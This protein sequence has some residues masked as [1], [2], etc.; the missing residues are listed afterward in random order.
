MLARRTSGSSRATR[1]SGRG[2]SGDALEAEQ[3]ERKALAEALHDEALQNLL[4]VRHVLEEIGE[5]NSDAEIARVDE[6]VAETVA[7]LRDV[8]LMSDILHYQTFETNQALGSKRF[9]NIWRQA[10]NS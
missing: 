6:T 3:R 7:Q 9:M 8:A 1:E 10:G 5:H 4:S 2:S